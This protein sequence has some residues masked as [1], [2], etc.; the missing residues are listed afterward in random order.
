M[1]A[2]DYPYEYLLQWNSFIVEYGPSTSLRSTLL[3]NVIVLAVEKLN[4]T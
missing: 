1:L 2:Y 3:K 4:R